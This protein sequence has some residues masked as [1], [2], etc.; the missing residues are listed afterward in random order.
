MLS[1]L[2]S[3]LNLSAVLCV[4]VAVNRLETCFR[5]KLVNSFHAHDCI[6]LGDFFVNFFAR[7]IHWMGAVLLSHTQ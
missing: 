3:Q 5:R 4:I 1:G 2:N 7:F 6:S